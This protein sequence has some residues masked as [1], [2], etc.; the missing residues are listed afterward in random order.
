MG[1]YH[2]AVNIDRKE[3]VHPHE[4]GDGLK[5]LEQ[6]Y[7]GPG[8][9]ATALHV[10]LA[11]CSR[12]GGGDYGSEHPLASEIVGRWGGDRIGVVGDYYQPGDLPVEHPDVFTLAMEE[13]TNI[14]PS[15]REY[16]AEGIDD[17]HHALRY[18]GDGWLDREFSIERRAG[19]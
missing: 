8:G 11:V 1:Q 6:A 19:R 12:R 9:L 5:L 16:L 18:S 14:T 17:Y 10:L 3:Y 15:V 2:I 13:W 4:L 7:S